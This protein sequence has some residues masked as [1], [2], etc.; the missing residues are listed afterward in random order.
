VP[1]AEPRT[2]NGRRGTSDTIFC[3]EPRGPAFLWRFSRGRGSLE[4][5]FCGDIGDVEIGVTP[6]H[7]FIVCGDGSRHRIDNTSELRAWVLELAGQV[8]AARA[9]VT[10]PIPVNP[11]M[12]QCRPCG[13]RLHCGQARL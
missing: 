8:R 13:M 5:W 3:T 7:G 10:V 12:G 4:G 2:H 6:P 9:A 1:H 11:K